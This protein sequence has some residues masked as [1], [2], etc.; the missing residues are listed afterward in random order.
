[1]QIQL[2]SSK[3]SLVKDHNLWEQQNFL[4]VTFFFSS[5]NLGIEHF[6]VTMSTFYNVIVILNLLW[7]QKYNILP[8]YCSIQGACLHDSLHS[9]PTL[10]DLMDYNPP[11]SSDH[12]IFQARILGWVRQSQHLQTKAVLYFASQSIYILCPSIVLLHQL[13]LLVQF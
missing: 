12:G 6:Q 7:L 10:C 1:M 8:S 11:G 13:E 4:T 3:D 5:S 9:C 2:F